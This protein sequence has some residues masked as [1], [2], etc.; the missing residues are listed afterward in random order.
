MTSALQHRGPDDQGIYIN[1]SMGFGHRRLSIIDLDSG[2]QPMSNEDGNL[3]ITFN[4]E[5]Y[6]FLEIRHELE[7]RH[8]FKE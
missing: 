2:Q 4:G 8:L 1:K 5:I 6:N 3:W 7:K